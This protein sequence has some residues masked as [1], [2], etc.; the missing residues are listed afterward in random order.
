LRSDMKNIYILFLSIFFGIIN[1]GCD[2][3]DFSLVISKAETTATSSSPI[4][5]PMYDIMVEKF[6]QQDSTR[7]V[8]VLFVVDNSLSMTVEQL[9]MSERFNSFIGSLH[10]VD[11]QIGITTTDVDDNPNSLQ[12]SLATLTGAQSE[13]ILKPTM[14]NAAAIFAQTVHRPEVGSGSEQPLKASIMAIDKRDTDNK[15]FFRDNA[16][17]VIVILSDEDELSTGPNN[18]TQPQQVVEHVKAV[19]GANKALQVYGIIIESNDQQC[20]DL[21]FNQEHGDSAAY[22]RL[23]SRLAYLTGGYTGSICLEDYSDILAD[24]GASVEQTLKSIELKNQ[25]IENSLKV[26]FIPS[27]NGVNYHVSGKKIIFDSNPVPG[28]EIIV[29]YKVAE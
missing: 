15:N 13:K 24:I 29:E 8:D 7:A 14:A 1:S 18:A 22:G 2:N 3:H 5:S 21:Q 26:T 12:G 17:L 25:P 28:T 20:L 16:Q 23:I 19:W 11:W 6:V 4:P 27:S 10:N 9:K